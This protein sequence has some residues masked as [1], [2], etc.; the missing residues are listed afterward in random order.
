MELVH[1]VLTVKQLI[2]TTVSYSATFNDGNY[3]QDYF[4]I[5]AF[6]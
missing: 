1:Y 4:M 3:W 2:L 6:K 5:V